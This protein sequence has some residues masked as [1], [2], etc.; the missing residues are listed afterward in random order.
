MTPAELLIEVKYRFTV[1]LHD[2]DA[3]LAA[4][5]RQALGQYQEKAGCVDRLKI[6]E[7]T[8]H[9]GQPA[10]A[11]PPE[12]LA[13]QQLKDATGNFV[14][15]EVNK[16]DKIVALHTRDRNAPL[17]LEMRYF[18]NLRNV[19]V[20]TF[21]LP[22]HILSLLMD[23]LEALIRIPNTARERNVLVAGGMDPSHLASDSELIE[24]KE[25]LELEMQSNR[26]ITP[27]ITI[28]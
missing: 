25:Q 2:D 7:L 21:Q 8:D 17:P 10:F 18:V 20:N 19:D 22:D 12:F 15:H 16:A 6:K 13:I 24:R 28:I 14:R 11:L 23:Y 27:M 1:L 5:L 3:R 26:V 4:L 9:D